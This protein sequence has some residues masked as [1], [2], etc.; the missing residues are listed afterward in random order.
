MSDLAEQFLDGRHH[1]QTPPYDGSRLLHQ[2]THGHAANEDST[3]KRR[4]QKTFKAPG[5]A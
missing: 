3:L 4:L 1:H 5:M 2:E